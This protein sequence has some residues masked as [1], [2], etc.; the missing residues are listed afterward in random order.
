L[1]APASRCGST[2][3]TLKHKRAGCFSCPSHPSVATEKKERRNE[4][5]QSRTKRKKKKIKIDG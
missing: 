3:R 1:P 4:D 2:I 5:D